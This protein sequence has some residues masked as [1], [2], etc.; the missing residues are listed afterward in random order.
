MV[1]GDKAYGSKV[2]RNYITKDGAAYC[3]PPKK[4]TP[5]PWECDWRQKQKAGRP[6]SVKRRLL[7]MGIGEIPK[8]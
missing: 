3:I 5:D 7:L 1:M 4:D 6:S 8:S 2:I